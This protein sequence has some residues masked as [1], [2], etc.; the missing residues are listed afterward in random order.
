MN[1]NI[2]NYIRTKI[3]NLAAQ[4]E[5]IEIRKEAGEELD[6]KLITLFNKLSESPNFDENV[7]AEM[8][9]DL[10]MAHIFGT[11]FFDELALR[12]DEQAREYE[13]FLKLSIEDIQEMSAI[14]VAK[15]TKQYIEKTGLFEDD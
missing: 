1:D 11:Y 13:A 15:Y 9:T 3:K 4:N 2:K 10:T 12:E 6:E 14:D 7:F 5:R 8:A